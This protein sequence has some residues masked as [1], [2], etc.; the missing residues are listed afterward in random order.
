MTDPESE[1][2]PIS[3]RRARTAD[4]EA[5]R[6]IYNRE[7]T[8]STVTMDLVP[9]TLDEQVAYIEHRSGA[10]GVLVAEE[11]GEI[12][13]FAS[14]S[15]H[16]DRPAY[17]TSVE[18]SVYVAPG[19]QGKG[20]GRLLLT[21]LITLA[22]EHGYHALFARI[23]GGHQV[24]VSLHESLGFELVGYER[25]VARKFGKWIDIAVMQLLL[26][27]REPRN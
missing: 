1:R 27:E 19:Q 12:R 7:V 16:R 9:R 4:A 10:L 5:I 17:R 14:I 15:A 2:S 13:G 11:A 23:A 18:N 8:E 21:S 3:I 22:S 25:E 24:S 20:I 6:I 26:Q